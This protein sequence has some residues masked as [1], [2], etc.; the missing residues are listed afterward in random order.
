MKRSKFWV[1]TKDI[2]LH[3]LPCLPNTIAPFM[4]VVAD[5]IN[6]ALKMFPEAAHLE[7]YYANIRDES[8]NPDGELCF[9]QVRSKV[10]L[11]KGGLFRNIKIVK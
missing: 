1:E 4:Q 5:R 8:R 11:R 2:S 9:L 7:I 10:G 6:E 3:D